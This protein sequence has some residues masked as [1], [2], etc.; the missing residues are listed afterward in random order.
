VAFVGAIVR[1]QTWFL[2]AMF[3]DPDYQ[4]RGIGNRL[5]QL[6]SEG[7][8]NRRMTITDAIQPISNALYAR[9][10]LIP[11][12]PILVM[13]GT[14]RIDD[15]TKLQAKTASP[16]DL[17]A[18]DQAGYGYDR[19][20]DHAFWSKQ[21]K[22]TLWVRDDKPMAYSYV[23]EEGWLGPLAGCDDAAAADALQAELARQ[24]QVTLEIPGSCAA[25]VETAFAAGLR[26]INPPG[27]LLHSR[28]VTP[29]T[30]LVIS[31]YWLL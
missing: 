21:A 27:L 14:P 11:S 25:L 10:G 17:A 28:P 9:H 20:E 7:W 5:L 23:S 13:S 4:G 3:V 24:T 29:P 6:A 19:R 8:P 15:T 26:I 30:A 31:G 12:T 22:V 1:G 16:A 2:S 18:L